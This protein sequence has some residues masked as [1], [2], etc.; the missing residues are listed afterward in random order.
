MDIKAIKEY[1]YVKRIKTK[2]ISMK[3]KEYLKVFK[4]KYQFWYF[5]AISTLSIET[6]MKVVFVSLVVALLVEEKFWTIML[7][8]FI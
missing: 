6:I 7:Q 8:Q 3:T 1:L 2:R 5:P 4:Q